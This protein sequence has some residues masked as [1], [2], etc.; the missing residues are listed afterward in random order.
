MADIDAAIKIKIADN[1]M[2]VV[3]NYT[4]PYGEGKI[5]SVNDVNLKLKAEGIKAG[6]KEDII[7]RMCE[8]KIP[9]P[10]VVIAEAVQPQYGQ[11]AKIEAYIDFNKK[12]KAI[13]RENGSMDFR[14]LGEVVSAVKGQKLFRKIPPTI[15]EA[16]FDVMGNQIPGLTGKDFQIVLGKGTAFADNDPNL[17][18]AAIDGEV[19]FIKGVVQI[20]PVHEVKGD[21][22]YETGNVVFKGTVKING[23]V[24]SGFR[25]EAEGDVEIRENVEDAIVISGNDVIIAGGC[26]GSGN[27]L[28]QAGRDITVKFVENQCLR[29]DRDIIILGDSYHAR[30][31]AGGSIM[32]KG[33]KS[34]IVGGV[35]EAKTSVETARLGSVACTPT[36]IKVGID[37]KLADRMKNTDEELAK[38]R[39]SDEKLEKSIIYLYKIKID[40][41]GHLPPD[42]AQLLEKLEETRKSLPEKIE[43]LEKYKQKLL[44][45]QKDLDKV[46]VSA[47]V[48]AFP[49]LQVYIGHQWLTVEDTLGPS[50]FRLI[51][52]SVARLSK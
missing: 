5:L 49:K 6:I 32:A 34:T 15:G 9:M 44:D 43:S 8:S 39:E 52:G 14:N 10:S 50:Q 48:S 20:A 45:D 29:A 31:F 27:S 3:A 19:Q 21:V 37:P 28:I 17:I 30:L 40:G 33:A 41:K 18:I 16:G 26:A 1:K 13:E 25:V 46:F 11:K 22:D 51:D 24:R 38:V 36:V 42:K 2:K 23:S 47:A 12:T 7:Q 4:P 35:C